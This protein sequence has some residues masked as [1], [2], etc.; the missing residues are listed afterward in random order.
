MQ[1]TR[2]H[3]IEYPP[4]PK[5]ITLPHFAHVVAVRGRVASS[6]S[7]TRLCR[8]QTYISVS[9]SSWHSGQSCH[10]PACPSSWWCAH[11]VYRLW[12]RWQLFVSYENKTYW[13]SSS[14]IHWPQH[15]VFV[16]LPVFPQNPQRGARLGNLPSALPLW[17]LV[18]GRNSLPFPRFGGG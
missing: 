9:K 2:S 14:Q 4:S 13:S 15:S 1:N 12:F 7:Y 6:R 10:A 5:W 17:A 11:R 16:N 18:T 8:D 3:L